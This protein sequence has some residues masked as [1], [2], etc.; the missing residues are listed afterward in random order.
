MTSPTP[1]D[2][3]GM[4]PTAPAAESAAPS[5]GGVFDAFEVFEANAWKPYENWA[6]DPL[7][8]E[9]FADA[10]FK[11]QAGKDGHEYRAAM[12]LRFT[13]S[14]MNRLG[15]TDMELVFGE[16]TSYDFNPK[17]NS[18]TFH[19]KYASSLMGTT[20]NEQLNAW[21]GLIVRAVGEHQANQPDSRVR[22][23]ID[24]LGKDFGK[25]N[26]PFLGTYVYDTAMTAIVDRAIAAHIAEEYPGFSKMAMDGLYQL[27]ALSSEKFF[28]QAE[29]ALKTGKN[30]KGEPLDHETMIKL[31]L[32]MASQYLQAEATAPGS[33]FIDSTAFPW[34][35]EIEKASTLYRNI[36]DLEADHEFAQLGSEQYGRVVERILKLPEQPPE[37]E[38]GE[39]EGDGSELPDLGGLQDH[40]AKVAATS[41][42]AGNAKGPSNTLKN[43]A[44][45]PTNQKV[46]FDHERFQKLLD[47]EAEMCHEETPWAEGQDKADYFTVKVKAGPVAR[48]RYGAIRRAYSSEIRTLR[49]II[50]D[51]YQ[52]RANTER[53]LRSGRPDGARLALTRFGK[54]EVFK[55]TQIDTDGEPIDFVVL[56]DESGSM[57]ASCNAKGYKKLPKFATGSSSGYR[58]MAG[59]QAD[60][61]RGADCAGG[62]RADVARVFGTMLHEATRN[63][64]GIRV[65]SYGYTTADPGDYGLPRGDRWGGCIVRQLGTPQDPN[66]VSLVVAES[67]N[68]DKEALV[69][70]LKTL[71]ENESGGARKAIVYLADGG[72]HDPMLEQLLK[73]AQKHM[74]IFFVD[75]SG[76]LRGTGGSLQIK[77]HNPVNSIPEAVKAIGKFFREVVLAA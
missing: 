65:W 17:T 20:A 24:D 39:G 44:N 38:G 73:N 49:D 76:S 66:G 62:T 60:A 35:M 77:Y 43:A 58:E 61:N 50:N 14:L 72:I 11:L 56:I 48:A 36:K 21:I 47:E 12:L 18:A 46:K 2:D 41:E 31:E 37:P 70:A 59:T 68:A 55:K 30:A 27:Q 54:Q 10:L 6:S 32:E 26:V 5:F 34:A 63:L 53:G 74:P 4:T 3:L 42:A 8:R 33:T 69:Q 52:I 75:M 25:F 71:K 40:H 15:A 57:G 67:G 28:A 16:K 22:Q 13:R 45:L 51:A 7:T 23:F 9:S 1:F 19:V 29:K 64:P